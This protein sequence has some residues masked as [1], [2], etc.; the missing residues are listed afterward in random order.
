V[1][2]SSG[3]SIVVT[4]MIAA[5]A[6]HGGATWAVL[7]YVLGLIE[8]GHHV[9]F[10]EPIMASKL[11][12]A[13]VTLARTAAAARFRWLTERF[14]F[15]AS[16]AMLLEDTTETVGLSYAAIREWARR[17][18][19][20]INISGLLKDA[21]LLEPIARR[22]YLDLDPGFNQVWQRAGDLDVRF[23]A[24]THFVTVGLAM[25]RSHCRVPTCGKRWIT[26]CPPV[27]LRKW[28][29]APCL[30]HDAF[31]TVANWRSYGSVQHD[32]MFLGQKV[33]ALRP[34]LELPRKT[35]A[36]FAL[37]LEIH[38]SEPDLARLRQNGWMLIDPKRA[39][40]TPL[41]YRRFVSGSRAE[42][43]LAKSGYVV[44]RSGWFSDRSACYLAAGRP[45]LAHDT[46]FGAALPTGKG[47][48]TF[49]NESDVLAGI[50]AIESDYCGHRE[51]ARAIAQSYFDSRRVLPR[52]ID[53]VGA[54]S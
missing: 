6:H 40:G 17:A 13:N 51:A 3:L 1:T 39:S 21:A 42:F 45:V 54:I 2:R 53:R 11:R 24:H 28:P 33:H 23:D 37:A 48:L 12:P 49:S 7:Q 26:T 27:L 5:D 10:I 50:D 34:L 52:L 46:G 30:R 47:L 36:H 20:L 38:P 43:G 18:D 4:G 25:G 44:S 9:C 16:A 15:S 35:K 41:A 14:G 19:L 31:T 29:V 32:G 22:V 8:L